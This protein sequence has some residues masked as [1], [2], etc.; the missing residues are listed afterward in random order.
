MS[1]VLLSGNIA[2]AED[3]KPGG[4]TVL[5]EPAATMTYG[6]MAKIKAAVEALDLDAREITLKGR[7]G[8]SVTLHVE[9]R[10][11]N[12]PEVQIGDEVTVRYYESVA[13]ELRKAQE[14][15]AAAPDEAAAKSAEPGKKMGAA[16][17]KTLTIIADV[18]AVSPKGKTVTLKGPNGDFVDLY[19]RDLK[20]L[21]SVAAGD[22]VIATFTEAAAV[23][24]ETPKEKEPKTKKKKKK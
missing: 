2:A 10:V 12:L 23:S 24:V 8:R 21:E 19:V 9:E 13:L 15:D 7:K 20:V 11:K 1:F 6:R 5:Q 18:D 4:I 17:V 22:K 14:G 16:A 3:V